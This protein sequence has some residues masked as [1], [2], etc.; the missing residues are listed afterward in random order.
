M[1]RFLSFLIIV[2]LVGLASGVK[3][4]D[5]LLGK[6][7]P[8][9]QLPTL[10]GE[11]KVK[12]NDFRGKPVLIDFWASWCAP[13]KKSLPELQKLESQ[14]PQLRILAINI[15]DHRERAVRFMENN[16]L[17]LT[18]LF[19]Q[20]KSVVEQYGVSAMP[21]ALLIDRKG[22]VQGVFSG[23]THEDMVDLKLEIERL[24]K[25]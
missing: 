4:M 6:P 22:V 17:D 5:Q 13:C 25:K 10:S 20:K 16:E 8:A 14:F 3:K 7:A 23:Y 1:K 18:V 2:S 15:D 9:F 12:L 19:D 11:A 21:S 24:L